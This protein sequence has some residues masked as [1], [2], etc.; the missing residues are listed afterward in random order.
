MDPES[1][2]LYVSQLALPRGPQRFTHLGVA[3]AIV[4]WNFPILLAVGKVTSALITGNCIIS[5]PSPFTPYYALK[6]AELAIPFFPKGVVQALSGDDSLEPLFTQHPGIRKIDFT[7]STETGKLVATAFVQVLKH[8]TLE[9]GG[10]IDLA[11]ICEDM[12]I[13]HLVKKII[14]GGICVAIE[15]VYFR[16]SIY[17]DLRHKVVALVKYLPIGKGTDPGVFFGPVQNHMHYS[18]A[19][20]LLVSVASDGLTIAL[21]CTPADSAGHFIP[22]T[23]VENTPD[24]SRLIVEEPFAPILPLM[25]WSTEE[26]V[27]GRAS[28]GATGL[29]GSVWCRDLHWAK[30]LARRISTGS[31]W[32]NSHF[33][34]E[35]H[36]PE[37]CNSQSIWLCNNV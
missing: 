20:N 27:I 22:P 6:L 34:V 3:A 21:K 13:D 23:V 30:R 29:G 1:N 12:E 32:V 25:K 8:C 11:L 28:F 4:P 7:G 10:G 37:Y 24:D 36:G 31:V 35:P 26:E 33:S 18:K 5:K 14:H 9:R 19:R 2:R 17:E 16:D 15:R